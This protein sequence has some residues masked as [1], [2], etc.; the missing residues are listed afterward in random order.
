MHYLII[1]NIN[2]FSVNHSNCFYTGLHKTKFCEIVLKAIDYSGLWFK[3][4]L[5]KTYFFIWAF[6]YR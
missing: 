6:S 3:Y 1:T 5:V 4:C 2:V